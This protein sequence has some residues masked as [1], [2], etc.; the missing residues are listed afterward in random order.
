MIQSCDGFNSSLG[1]PINN[2]QLC[3]GGTYAFLEFR[4]EELAETAMKFNGM[5]LS[6]RQLKVRTSI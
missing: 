4:D 2:V 5:E 3:G 6:G 1:P